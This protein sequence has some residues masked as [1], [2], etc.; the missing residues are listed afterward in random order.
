[1]YIKFN[2]KDVT[3][4][5]LN[6]IAKILNIPSEELTWFY[7]IHYEACL[8]EIEC[9]L[10]NNMELDELKAL[11]QRDDYEDILNHLAD[12]LYYGSDWPWELLC[13]KAG[14]IVHNNNII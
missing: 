10:D 13:E 12:E 5:Q 6:E 9:Y 14:E 11:K 8:Y 1:M 2:D 4:G 3:V 7:N